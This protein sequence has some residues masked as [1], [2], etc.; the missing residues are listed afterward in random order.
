MDH[1]PVATDHDLMCRY[2]QGDA[3]AF[4][5]L[6]RRWQEPVGRIVSHLLG[7]RADVEDLCQEVFIRVLRARERY[8]PSYAFSTWMYRIALNVARDSRRRDSRRP[9]QP[10]A[11]YDATSPAPRPADALARNETTDA[12]ADAVA[13]LP[14]PLRDVLVLKHFGGLS[15]S[16]VAIATGLP[17]GTVKSRML[18]ALKH[19]RGELRRRGVTDAE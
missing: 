5:L 10:L 1:S 8:R 13:G 14:A 2:R 15:F 9:H 4:E 6:V 12:V 17:L 7:P 11:D 18:A 3:A 16:E 19:L